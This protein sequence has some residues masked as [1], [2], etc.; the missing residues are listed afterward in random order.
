M[1]VNVEIS[2]HQVWV[3]LLARAVE[4]CVNSGLVKS[5][6]KEARRKKELRN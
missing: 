4:E 6:E 3:R 5:G 2:N 1:L